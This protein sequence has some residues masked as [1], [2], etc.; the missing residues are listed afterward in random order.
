MSLRAMT[1]GSSAVALRQFAANV[2]GVAWAALI[3]LAFTP[4]Y[5]RLVGPESY[6][7]IGFFVT[8][9]ALLQ[10]FDLGM[11]PTVNRE[12][13]RFSARDGSAA[14]ASR[15]LFTFE[16]VYWGLAVVVAVALAAATPLIAGRWLKA[17]TLSTGVMASCFLRMALLT[18]LQWPITL[19]Q[20]ALRGLQR[21]VSW[22]ALKIGAVT[23]AN[24]IAVLFLRFVSNSIVAFFTVQIVVAVVHVVAL[25]IWTWRHMPR[26]HE[27]HFTSSFLFDA[28]RF[29]AAMT[30][31]TVAAVVI[32]QADKVV[33]SAVAP[34][35]SFGYYVVAAM[36][37]NAL[38]IVIVPVFN[39]L[40]PRFA[41]LSASGRLEER[42][43]TYV[44]ALEGIAALL[45][46]IAAVIAVFS[47][48]ILRLWTGSDAAA[49]SAAPVASLLVVGTALNGIMNIP[50]ALQIAE[51]WLRLALILTLAQTAL[52]LPLL[53][54][55]AWRFGPVGAAAAWPIVGAAYV[56]AGL[57]L[58][59]RRF[60]TARES[61]AAAG[62]VA[63]AIVIAAACALA[64]RFLLARSLP[65][66]VVTALFAMAACAAATPAVRR[67]LTV[68]SY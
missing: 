9:A 3:Q 22:N 19:Y 62:G 8:L 63:R 17:S 12:L 46:P 13:A 66:V 5:L 43:T 37:A 16:V 38:L 18:A 6:G 21:H 45:A 36:A 60:L 48:E 23:A 55:L 26:P 59:Q 56:C 14:A 61:L 20:A 1:S 39:T 34:L 33:V 65:M 32:S 11:S 57:P 29:S 27:R 49:H 40:M 58:T 50:Y 42:K 28:W 35:A 52:Y 64:G 31:I 25:R 53:C 47:Y 54:I 7:L 67:W 2:A 30:L 15:F 4:L 68:R 10:V 24:L 44:A 51:G 41:Y